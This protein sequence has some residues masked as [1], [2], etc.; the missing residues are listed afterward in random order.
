[1]T[2]GRL[3]AGDE[4]WRAAPGRGC[5]CDEG[6]AAGPRL[7]DSEELERAER[8]AHRRSGDLEL[9]RER[10]LGRELIAGPQLALFK[11][12]L[13]LLDDALVEPA[14]PDGL[15]YGQFGPPQKR[16]VRWSDQTRERLRPAQRFVNTTAFGRRRPGPTL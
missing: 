3:W 12:R 7:D 4:M 14:A 15:D 2:S 6:A 10:A 16:L 1:M 5:D 8:L 9:L 13:D 11:E